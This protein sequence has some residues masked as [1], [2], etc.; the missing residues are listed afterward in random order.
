M[1]ISLLTLDFETCFAA[2]HEAIAWEQRSVT[3]YGKT[4]PQPRLTKWY[5]EVPY[6]YSGLRWEPAPMPALLDR[7]RQVV[8]RQAGAKFN[9]VLCNLYRDGQDSVGWHADDEPLFGG[10]PVVGSVSYGAPRL[11]KLR[12]NDKTASRDII[13][14]D[15][16]LLVMGRSIQK[17]WQHCIPKTAQAVGP[18]INLTFRQIVL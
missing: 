3:V 8:E 18:R 10:D 17:D 16:Q 13:L 1:N 15:S 11:F 6:C 14:L 4:H 9:S 7:I 12:R 2:V 5:G